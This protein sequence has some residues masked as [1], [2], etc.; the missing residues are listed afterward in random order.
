MRLNHSEL[1]AV[2]QDILLSAGIS[3]EQ[4]QTVTENLI[5]CDM[6]GRRN[7]GIERL[8]ILLKHVSAGT[9][10]SAP[11]MKF[12]SLSPTM[13][14][15]DADQAFGHHAGRIAIDRAI[16]LSETF[17]IGIVG[18]HNS[19]FFGAGAYYAAR[20]AEAGKLSLVL[21]NSFPKVAA[22]GGL[23]AVLGTNPFTFGAPRRDGHHV[24]VDMSTAAVAGSTVR[25]KIVAG[26]TFEPGVAIDGEGNPILDPN[27]VMAGT[28]LPAAG[29]KGFGLALM[30]EILSAVLT[31]AAI[32]HQVGSMYK[33]FERS[34][35]NGH[36]FMV[37]NTQVWLSLETYFDR[38][39]A[40]GAALNA[41]P[42]DSETRFPG[43]VRWQQYE[44]S[45]EN[46]V[47][48]D[49]NMLSSFMAL[50]EQQGVTVPW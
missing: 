1:S 46:G 37:L 45:L 17:G 39:D 40:L 10:R 49:A 3:S 34:G 33:N 13:E 38:M 12:D 16:E 19:N 26:E 11:N 20:A 35:E 4:A 5:W 28:L 21:S 27:E 29:A 32:S 50:A 14:R 8:P 9:L 25:E 48:V 30:V 7:H 15:L 42:Q 31:G 24:L 6:V 23:Q 36:F 22:P 18:V 41:T 43:Q 44:D 47:E 2:T